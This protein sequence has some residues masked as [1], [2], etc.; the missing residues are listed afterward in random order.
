MPIASFPHLPVSHC[1][2]KV[3]V[4]DIPSYQF[5]ALSD[6]R[7]S[8]P[9]NRTEIRSA[10]ATV[11]E[12]AGILYIY[13]LSRR[14]TD[15]QHPVSSLTATK[16]ADITHRRRPRDRVYSLV[17]WVSSSALHHLSFKPRES[18][19]RRR[20]EETKTPNVS[21]CDWEKAHLL[22]PLLTRDIIIF[23][24]AI[25]G[26]YLSVP[27]QWIIVWW[28]KTKPNHHLVQRQIWAQTVG[29]PINL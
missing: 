18:K 7:I 2:S 21:R 20:Q 4:A 15:I 28:S 25:I 6:G 10:L 17:I 23:N 8:E 22:F 29:W 12:A 1:S 13:F 3:A 26:H 24:L 16:T 11:R 5:I 27:A 19:R 14:M 9:Q